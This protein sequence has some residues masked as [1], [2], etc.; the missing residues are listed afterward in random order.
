M[1]ETSYTHE[2][3]GIPKE[4]QIAGRTVQIELDPTLMEITKKEGKLDPGEDSFNQRGRWG[5]A[6]V[7]QDKIVMWPG[8]ADFLPPVQKI[9]AAFCEEIIHF[10]TFVMHVNGEDLKGPIWRNEHFCGSQSELIYQVF[11]QLN[12]F[13]QAK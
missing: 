3:I 12:A 2:D 11:K 6:K 1:H 7:K 5:L 10:I 4:L 9:Q 8:N 13:S